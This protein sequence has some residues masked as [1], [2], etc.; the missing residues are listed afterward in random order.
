VATDAFTAKFNDTGKSLP[1]RQRRAL[2]TAPA[3]ALPPLPVK[4][5][6]VP[7]DGAGTVP[8]TPLPT[9]VTDAALPPAQAP[10][11]AGQTIALRPPA[12]S[13][14]RDAA[15][16]RIRHLRGQV[17]QDCEALANTAKSLGRRIE[18]GE[19]PRQS[20]EFTSIAHQLDQTCA[21]LYELLRL[22]KCY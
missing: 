8:A 18:A 7:Q 4:R 13:A 15:E 19:T 1:P 17:R 14:I 12:S 20:G 22:V 5:P 21:S 9:P 6:K 3:D 10:R 11:E 16:T 2:A